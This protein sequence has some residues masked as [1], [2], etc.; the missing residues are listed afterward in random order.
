MATYYVRTDG[1][2]ANTGTGQ[3]A[4]QAWATVAYALSSG[5]GFAS[6]DTLYVAPG[7]YTTQI[8][9]TM[10]NPTVETNIIGDPTCTVFTGVT[11]APVVITN[12]NSTLSANGY[13]GNVISATTKNYLHFQN[14]QFKLSNGGLSFTTCTNLKFTKCGF[15]QKSQATILTVSSPTS[16]AVNLV[17][18]R[19]IFFLWFNTHKY[20]WTNCY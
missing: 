10:A 8:S 19:C 15:T 3:L 7:I 16:T 2:N 6:G 4:G 13:N 1:S 12:Y 5:S 9:V 18:D 14:I 11:A 17:V 20:N